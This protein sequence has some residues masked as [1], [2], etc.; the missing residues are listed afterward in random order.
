MCFYKISC[1]L[2]VLRT[3]EYKLRSTVLEYSEYLGLRIV[4]CTSCLPTQT[5]YSEYGVLV[6]PSIEYWSTEEEYSGVLG[7]RST[8]VAT[9]WTARKGHIQ[10]E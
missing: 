2:G 8:A 10:K 7:V 5:Q 6:L 3:P 9:P 1:L 4:L